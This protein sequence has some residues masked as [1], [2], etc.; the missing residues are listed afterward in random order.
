MFLYNM[1]IDMYNVYI[2][3]IKFKNIQNC[4]KLRLPFTAQNNFLNLILKTVKVSS[5]NYLKLRCYNYIKL[6]DALR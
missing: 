3:Y 6:N 1:L 2:L 5:R 4:L